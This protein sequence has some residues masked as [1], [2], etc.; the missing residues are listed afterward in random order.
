MSEDFGELWAKF[1]HGGFLV[2]QRTIPNAWFDAGTKAYEATTNIT[3]SVTFRVAGH[4]NCFN[5]KLTS[6]AGSTSGTITYV[7]QQVFP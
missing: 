1:M 5:D 4:D 6:F 7:E 2:P 3:D